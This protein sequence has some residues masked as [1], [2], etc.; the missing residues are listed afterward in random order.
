MELDD[1]QLAPSRQMLSR[2]GNMSSTTVLF[3]LRQM[4]EDGAR[5][6]CAT[7]AFGPGLM[8]EGMLLSR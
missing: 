4:A 6:R 2:L 1:E 5:G 8:M 7:V 3:I